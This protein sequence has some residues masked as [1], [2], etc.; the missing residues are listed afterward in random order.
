M[1]SKGV[2]L[3][4]FGEHGTA[5]SAA[6]ELT[7]QS[8]D[9]DRPAGRGPVGAVVAGTLRVFPYNC[10]F[11]AARH[12]NGFWFAV[13]TQPDHGGEQRQALEAALRMRIQ[14]TTDDDIVCDVVGFAH[15]F[16]TSACVDDVAPPVLCALLRDSAQTCSQRSQPN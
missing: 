11:D 14:Q 6:L 7:R 3:S 9:H 16:R 10:A 12:R 4:L 15:V 2:H 1:Q 8:L 5:E 13:G